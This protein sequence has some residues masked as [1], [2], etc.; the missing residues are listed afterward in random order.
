[1]AYALDVDDKKLI[2]IRSKLTRTVLWKLNKIYY[3][4]PYPCPNKFTLTDDVQDVIRF[5]ENMVKDIELH[6]GH[7]VEDV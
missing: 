4:L 5:V 1:M 6:I 3:S 7:K 2:E